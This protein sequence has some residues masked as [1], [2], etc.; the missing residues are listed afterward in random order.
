MA[1]TTDAADA[2]MRRMTSRT[3]DEFARHTDRFRAEHG[4]FSHL[5]ARPRSDSNPTALL[6]VTW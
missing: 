5:A 3:V 6:E 1:S 2:G 4:A